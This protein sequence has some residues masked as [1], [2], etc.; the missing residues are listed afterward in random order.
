M[1]GTPITMIIPMMMTRTRSTS[2]TAMMSGRRAKLADRLAAL[3]D[4][5][6]DLGKAER[7]LVH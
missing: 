5:V 2:M 7:V 1:M 6:E 4:P 3:T